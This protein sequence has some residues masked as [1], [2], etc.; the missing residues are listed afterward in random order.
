MPKVLRFSPPQKH[1][2][3]S[4]RGVQKMLAH[5]VAG[6]MLF[7]ERQDE[8]NLR[9]YV[10]LGI[11]A[12]F[13]AALK[14]GMQPQKAVASLLE[15]VTLFFEHPEQGA[16]PD[17]LRHAAAWQNYQIALREA[18][19][20]ASG[21]GSI[22]ERFMRGQLA[23]LLVNVVLLSDLSLTKAAYAVEAKWPE[24][25]DSLPE[26]MQDSVPTMTAARAF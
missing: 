1:G 14:N 5:V 13:S 24:F 16:I 21:K 2:A 22:A 20:P 8:K 17:K 15:V 4:Y 7:P 26:W 10:S 25:K 19:F 18:R 9:S 23:G 3:A 11:D 6:L 12:A